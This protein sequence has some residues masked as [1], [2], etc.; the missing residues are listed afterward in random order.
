[1]PPRVYPLISAVYAVGM[2][3]YSRQPLTVASQIFI[4]A[5]YQPQV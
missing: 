5:F 1:M 4:V 3:H 2:H